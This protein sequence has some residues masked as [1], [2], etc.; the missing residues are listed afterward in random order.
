[1]LKKTLCGCLAGCLLLF[2]LVERVQAES[3]FT[4]RRTIG[5]QFLGSS[6]NLAKRAVDFRRDLNST[7]SRP[8]RVRPRSYSSEQATGIQKARC[9]P[10][11]PLSCS[12][13]DSG[14]SCPAA[15]TTISRRCV[16]GSGPR[17][18]TFRFT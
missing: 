10:G 2:S 12:S 6:A 7:N 16:E 1:M 18:R 9:R 4:V 17:V 13:V 14:F 8:M 3:F 11:F 5:V 15:W